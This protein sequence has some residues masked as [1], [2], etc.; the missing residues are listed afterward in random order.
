[1]VLAIFLKSQSVVYGLLSDDAV[2]G[3][4]CN[5]GKHLDLSLRSNVSHFTISFAVLSCNLG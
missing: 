3:H 2:I 4:P 5:K 1:M